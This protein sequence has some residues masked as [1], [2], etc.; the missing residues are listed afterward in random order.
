[1]LDPDSGLIS[2]AAQGDETAFTELVEKY[3]HRVLATIHRY[4]QD[5]SASADL[6]QEVFIKVWEK[7]RTFSGKSRFSTWLYRIVV[8]HCMNHRAKRKRT[9]TVELNESIP[10]GSRNVEETH[11]YKQKVLNLKQAVAELP[12]R[13]R[14][15]LILFKFEEYPVREVAR[16]MGLSFSAT[17]SLIFRAID[18]LRKQLRSPGG[19]RK[20]PQSTQRA[21]R[22][23]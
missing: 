10:D 22:G 6:A 7:A 17:Q 21:Q 20:T 16:I 2:R 23:N 8:N 5:P 9:R 3:K 14:M 4:V 15:V 1:M 11:D 13:Q 19:C 18:N 12:G